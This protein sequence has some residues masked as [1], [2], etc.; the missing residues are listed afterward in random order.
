MNARLLRRA[1][2]RATVQTPHGGVLYLKHLPR[3]VKR[4]VKKSILRGGPVPPD[5]GRVVS[6]Y[7]QR[8]GNRDQSHRFRLPKA[9]WGP[10]PWQDEP[11]RVDFEHAGLPCA[12]IRNLH[13]TGSLCGYVGVPDSHPWWGKDAHTCVAT[14]QCPEPPPPDFEQWAKDGMPVPPEGSRWRAS[15]QEP[16][17]SCGHTIGSMVSVHGGITWAST[18]YFQTK[19]AY[20]DHWWFGFDC[21]HAGD[22]SP[23]MK[24]TLKQLH[25]LQDPAGKLAEYEASLEE[26]RDWETYRDLPY[27]R[28]EVE[29]LAEQIAMAAQVRA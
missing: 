8:E 29:R 1:R 23:M 25:A 27:V 4:I 17:W 13:V 10:G 16:T 5:E 20:M 2:G 18:A 7:L 14:P 6:R 22:V 28:H 19:S 3:R 11:D 15:M 12:I 9:K 26:L 24:A 21:G